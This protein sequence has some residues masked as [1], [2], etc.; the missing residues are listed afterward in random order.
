MN[1]GIQHH[2]TLERLIV[3]EAERFGWTARVE[4]QD[5]DPMDPG[6]FGPRPCPGR[7]DVIL[8]R[9]EGDGVSFEYELPEDPDD[10]RNTIRQLIAA[11]KQE[12][13]RRANPKGA[14]SPLEV[15]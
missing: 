12:R 8:S 6:V 7:G 13:D 3:A 4:N 14:S 10:I 2:G 11:D 15:G 9:Y 1:S 5:V